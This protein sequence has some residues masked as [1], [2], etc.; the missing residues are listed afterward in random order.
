MN[1][2]NR[3]A[4]LPH[5]VHRLTLRSRVQECFTANLE[6]MFEHVQFG[7]RRVLSLIAANQRKLKRMV[8]LSL[9]SL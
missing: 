2:G 1:L 7:F 4:C 9:S 3:L 8:Y 5:I 6:R